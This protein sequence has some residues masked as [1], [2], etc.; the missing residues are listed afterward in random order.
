MREILAKHSINYSAERS[1]PVAFESGPFAWATMSI[2]ND[3]D[4]HS[5]RVY[6]ERQPGEPHIITSVKV[7]SAVPQSS[8]AELPT[9]QNGN[10]AY[11]ALDFILA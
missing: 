3:P 10:A 2:R 4:V 6:V 5:E 11:I 8:E 1:D 7:A 9:T